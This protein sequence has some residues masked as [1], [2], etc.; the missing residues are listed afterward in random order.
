MAEHTSP[1]Y[2]LAVNNS[3]L[4]T[5]GNKSHIR[6]PALSVVTIYENVFILLVGATG[7]IFNTMLLK[8]LVYNKKG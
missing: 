8:A 4:S 6:W 3:D 2:T 5:Y 7:L 1:S